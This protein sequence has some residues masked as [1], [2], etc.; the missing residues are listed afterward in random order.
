MPV[1]QS[2]LSLTLFLDL[3][4]TLL[5]FAIPLSQ[6]TFP[7]L[8]Q[9]LCLSD[10]DLWLSFSQ[11]SQC[12][13]EIPS[14]IAKKITPFQQVSFQSKT[15]HFISQMERLIIIYRVY[16]KSTHTLKNFMYLLPL[17]RKFFY[18]QFAW[19]FLCQLADFSDFSMWSFIKHIPFL[20][21]LGMVRSNRT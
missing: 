11:S 13:Q 21:Y 5:T 4:F 17:P 10:S 2:F 14:S 1:K 3:S 20:A 19:L 16:Q 7:A 18:A 9:C 6:T 15:S 12:E 8:Y